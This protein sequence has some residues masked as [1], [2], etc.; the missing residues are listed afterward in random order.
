VYER[1]VI[2]EGAFTVTP[3]A[4][5]SPAQNVDEGKGDPLIY[6]YHDCLFRTWVEWWDRATPEEN[7]EWYAAGTLESRLGYPG[8]VGDLFPD[9]AAFVADLERWWQLYQG[10]SVAKRIQAPPVLAVTRRAFGFDHRES[11]TGARFTARYLE[12]RRQVLGG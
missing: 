9:A 1:P 4:E 10:L 3:S 11:Q 8:R 5:L 12:L 2:P 6:P 7:L